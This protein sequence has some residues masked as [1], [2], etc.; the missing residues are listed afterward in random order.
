MTIASLS[1]AIIFA[2]PT[3]SCPAGDAPLSETQACSIIQFCSP[4]NPSS[5]T[6]KLELYC[7]GRKNDRNLIQ[8]ASGLGGMLGVL[9]V[10]WLAD[11]KGKRFCIILSI[12]L[13]ALHSYCLL[14]GILN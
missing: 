14:L 10:N 1:P 6:S 13:G 5:L 12:F 3:F 11:R 9:M 7:D 8:S 2:N 4:A